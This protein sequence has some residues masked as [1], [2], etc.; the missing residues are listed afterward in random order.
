MINF[1]HWKKK[2]FWSIKA[3]HMNL[4]N[5]SQIIQENVF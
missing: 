3:H 1:Q 4:I 5:I 2:A